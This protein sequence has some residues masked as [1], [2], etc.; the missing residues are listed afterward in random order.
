M[1]SACPPKLAARVIRFQR[2]RELL[3]SP[4]RPGLADIALACGYYD[5]AHLTRDWRELAGCSPTVWMAEELV[6]D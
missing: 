3:A 1:S 5:Q 6:G 4:G 2:S